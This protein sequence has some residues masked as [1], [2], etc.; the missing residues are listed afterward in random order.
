MDRMKPKFVKFQ[1]MHL[2]ISSAGFVSA[3][4]RLLYFWPRQNQRIV[5]AQRSCAGFRNFSGEKFMH[6][7]RAAG[8]R[9]FDSLPSLS[10]VG[11]FSFR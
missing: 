2:V 6:R 1:K 4:D 5:S 8:P 11:T 3:A 10:D 9:G 7:A